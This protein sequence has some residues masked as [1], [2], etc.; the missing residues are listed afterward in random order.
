VAVTNQAFRRCN[1]SGFTL[2][3]LLVVIAI[4][5]LLASLLL[6]TLAK[7][8]ES[9]KRAKCMS[10]QRQLYLA[11]TMYTGENDGRI[12]GNHD[13]GGLVPETP[14]WVYGHM[15]YENDP[16]FQAVL[17]HNTNTSFIIPGRHGSIGR[18]VGSLGPYRCPSDVSWVM[19]G[20]QRYNRLR[21]YSM[22]PNTGWEGMMDYKAFYNESQISDVGAQSIF[23]FTDEHEDSIEDGI[24]DFFSNAAP[25]SRHSQGAVFT[26]ADGWTRLKKWTDHRA[27]LP[28]I[29]KR[30]Y[31]PD[32]NLVDMQWI[33]ANATVP[34]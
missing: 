24:F 10:N 34:K 1:A 21:S 11:W 32:E 33:Q 27:R 31:A 26:F 14:A 29:R 17:W 28:V 20:G 5:A 9:A 13:M 6:P 30:Q 2:V 16:N 15:S 25:S 22:N 23:I 8:K 18:Y 3:E 12:P 19:I 7:S 4:I